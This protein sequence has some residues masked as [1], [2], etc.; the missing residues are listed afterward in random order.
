MPRSW[1]SFR[2]ERQ[3]RCLCLPGIP[4]TRGEE[5]R[6]T[7]EANAAPLCDVSGFLSNRRE[8]LATDTPTV[9]KSH[10]GLVHSELPCERFRRREILN[11]RHPG[12]RFRPY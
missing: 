8:M 3:G 7:T 5:S 12:E 1:L 9:V 11:V 2:T 6:P 10:N 4:R